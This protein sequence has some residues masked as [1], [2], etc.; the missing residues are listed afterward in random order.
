[1]WLRL[2]LIV[3]SVRNVGVL[4]VAMP[5]QAC[6]GH[7]QTVE[8]GLRQIADIKPQALGLAPVLDDELQKDQA[9]ARIAEV[10][11]RVKVDVQL[12]IGLQEPEVT[13]T[14][15][16]SQAHTRSDPLPAQIAGKILV[17]SIFV[18]KNRIR[19]IA[20]Q[21]LV[22]VVLNWSVKV[23]LALIDQL[24][25]RVCEH[26]LGQ[27]RGVHNGVCI[28]RSSLGIAD[29]IGLHIADLA[30]IDDRNG[31]ALGVGSVHDLAHFRV[32]RGAARNRLC[33]NCRRSAKDR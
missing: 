29:S 5:N 24:H 16:M 27:R 3:P 13:E 2:T 19:A 4:T 15:R 31:H 7:P 14:R 1:M 28:E 25:H 26:R 17:W 10:R 20:R 6:T 21:R 33:N 30:T 12:P 32:D 23:K 18:R 11:S 8:V 22:E 9:F